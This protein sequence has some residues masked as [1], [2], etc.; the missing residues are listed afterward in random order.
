MAFR[1]LSV[2]LSALLALL[3]VV[4]AN[5]LPVGDSH[6]EDSSN[7]T[8]IE[9]ADSSPLYGFYSCSDDQKAKISKAFEDAVRIV[10]EG[11]DPDNM[12]WN[13]KM[14]KD[15]FGPDAKDEKNIIIG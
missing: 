7:A 8:I 13:S 15:Y 10:R 4:N 14:V 12:E 6:I 5:P 2:Y 9:R 11:L 1:C 3:S